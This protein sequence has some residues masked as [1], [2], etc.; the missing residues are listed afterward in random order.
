MSV[1][2]CVCQM[3]SRAGWQMTFSGEQERDVALVWLGRGQSEGQAWPGGYSQP[4]NEG[5]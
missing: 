4:E 2:V 1:C 5:Y 3:C